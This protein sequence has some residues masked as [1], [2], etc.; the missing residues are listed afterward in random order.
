MSALPLSAL[1]AADCPESRQPNIP[2]SEQPALNIDKHKK[3]LT[4]YHD[5]EYI[6]DI[7]LVLEDA[8]KYVATRAAENKELPSDRIKQLAIVLDIDETSLSNWT[9]IGANNFGFIPKGTCLLGAG[10][11]CGFDEWINMGAAPAILPTLEFFK[12]VRSNY[13]AVFFVTG[14]RESQRVA[15]MTN[16]DR[17]GFDSWAGLTTRPNEQHGSIVP[18][19]SGER[20]RIVREKNYTI[21][22]NIGD[23]TSDL[24]E[25]DGSRDK[26]SE[27]VFKLP[28]PFYFID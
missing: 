10:L 15:T 1:S 8:H 13:I 14:R 21:V 9:N 22:A 27:C 2:V 4:E 5:R 26:S 17:A 11:A 18:F 19:K 20:D 7:A 3:Q 25:N 28:N 12:F 16:L 6:K 23:Q 24:V